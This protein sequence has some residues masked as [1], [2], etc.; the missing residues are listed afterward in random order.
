MDGGLIEDRDGVIASGVQQ[1]NLDHRDGV[2]LMMA[3][4]AK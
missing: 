3:K 4:A 1:N 2:T